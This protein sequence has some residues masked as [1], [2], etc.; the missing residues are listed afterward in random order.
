MA[1]T[2]LVAAPPAELTGHLVDTA[3]KL[4]AHQTP[5]SQHEWEQQQAHAANEKAAKRAAAEA[6]AAAAG[7][8]VARA[9][10]AEQHEDNV[11]HDIGNDAGSPVPHASG[12]GAEDA[13]AAQD[14]VPAGM[15]SDAPGH[16]HTAGSCSS[17]AANTA[18]EF[19]LPA[20]VRMDR[21]E[22]HYARLSIGQHA[23]RL[24]QRK[25]G[26]TPGDDFRRSLGLLDDADDF[27]KKRC[28]ASV[29]CR[30]SIHDLI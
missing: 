19:P 6:A 29:A 30:L 16:A 10:P 21:P 5:L 20:D 8:M 7:L 23:L 11:E 3:S 15:F 24:A 1:G 2:L 4:L 12:T 26:Q 28:G 27:T 17:C 25:T 18:P 9:E 22:T 13:D 14:C